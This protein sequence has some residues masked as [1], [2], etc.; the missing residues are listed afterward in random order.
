MLDC[1]RST[2]VA[3]AENTGV[4]L[5]DLVLDGLVSLVAW[6]LLDLPLPPYRWAGFALAI[7]AAVVL[8]TFAS[9]DRLERS[10]RQRLGVL[11]IIAGAH[12]HRRL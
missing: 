2:D 3:I 5:A 12:R 10:G 1:S 4:L 8:G 6:F 7:P 11:A 9:R